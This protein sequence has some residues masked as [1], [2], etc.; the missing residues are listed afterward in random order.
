MNIDSTLIV[1]NEAESY[2]LNSRHYSHY[3]NFKM[4]RAETTT[5][6]GHFDS[7]MKLSE[8]LIAFEYSTNF[9]K[10]WC[11]LRLAAQYLGVHD[12]DKTY[13]FINESLWL[14]A[15]EGDTLILGNI[16]NAYGG[17]EYFFGSRQKAI[18]YY[19]KAIPYLKKDK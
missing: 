8:E 1:L 18:D 3:V 17:I 14:A 5:M 11:Y 16:Y 4:A 9:V 15:R 12:K 7:S 2:F 19:I 6:L 13:F 10:L